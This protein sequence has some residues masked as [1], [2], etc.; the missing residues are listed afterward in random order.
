M[1]PTWEAQNPQSDEPHVQFLYFASCPN[2]QVALSFLRET[3]LAEDVASDIE[4]ITVETDEAAQRY[5]FVGSPTI[6]V[7]G[8]DVMPPPESATPS[9][10]CRLYPQVDGHYAPHPPTAALTQALRY[11]RRLERDSDH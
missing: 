3:L 5:G 11:A 7:N 4:M 2:A 6:R 8:V 9:L 1:E 10:A